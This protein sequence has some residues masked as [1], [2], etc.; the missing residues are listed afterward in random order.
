MK[1]HTM[2]SV[3]QSSLHLIIGEEYTPSSSCYLVYIFLFSS[4]IRWVIKVLSLFLTNL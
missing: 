4:V 2:G 1:W 3:S